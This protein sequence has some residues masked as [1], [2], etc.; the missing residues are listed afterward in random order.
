MDGKIGIRSGVGV[1]RLDT[2]TVMLSDGSRLPA[3]AV[4]YATGFGSMEA[5][6]SRLIDQETAAKIG[7]CWG[8]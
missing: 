6:V 3:D 2:K 5:W 7:R 4:I 8:Y 1:D